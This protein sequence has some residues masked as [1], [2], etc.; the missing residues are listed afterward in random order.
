MGDVAQPDGFAQIAHVGVGIFFGSQVL[1]H[2]QFRSGA[3]RVSTSASGALDGRMLLRDPLVEAMPD[4]RQNLI[5]FEFLEVIQVVA[6]RFDQF[7]V[8]GGLGHRR[9][10]PAPPADDPREQPAIGSAANSANAAASPIRPRPS[11]LG[12]RQRSA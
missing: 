3:G 5:G 7:V 11:P 12:C 9:A 1:Q 10:A 6:E 4:L 2:A 8:R